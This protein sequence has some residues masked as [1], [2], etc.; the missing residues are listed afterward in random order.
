MAKTDEFWAQDSSF[1]TVDFRKT[2]TQKF[3]QNLKSMLR[4]NFEGPPTQPRFFKMDIVSASDTAECAGPVYPDAENGRGGQQLWMC[5]P[6]AGGRAH[7]FFP[8]QR[9]TGVRA[10]WG[11]L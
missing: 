7:G 3:R 6:K 9:K 11:M 10:P 8:S 4:T 5:G 1:K 2:K